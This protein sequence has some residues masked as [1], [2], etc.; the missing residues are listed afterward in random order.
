MISSALMPMTL[1]D[2]VR[3]IKGEFVDDEH[4]GMSREGWSLELSAK[5]R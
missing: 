1:Q 3:F 5:L 2:R 4:Y